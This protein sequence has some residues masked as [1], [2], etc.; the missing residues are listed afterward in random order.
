MKDKIFRATYIAIML[1]LSSWNVWFKGWDVGTKFGYTD[2]M[3]DALLGIHKPV[4]FFKE[5]F[6]KR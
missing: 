1:T 3:A 5:M 2:A 4:D 6:K